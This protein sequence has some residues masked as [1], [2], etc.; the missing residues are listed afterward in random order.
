MLP[1][2]VLYIAAGVGV[3]SAFVGALVIAPR[4]H[5]LHRRVA[6]ME[7]ASRWRCVVEGGFDPRSFRDWHGFQDR[8]RRYNSGMDVVELWDDKGG[9]PRPFPMEPARG[10]GS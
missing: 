9:I 5:N 4:V 2:L 6:H 1:E 3:G 7:E 8:C 10:E